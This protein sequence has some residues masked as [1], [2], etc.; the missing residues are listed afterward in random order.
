MRSDALSWVWD[1][2]WISSTDKT[3][4][5]FLEFHADR[6]N[7]VTISKPQLADKCGMS[8]RATDQCIKRLAHLQLISIHTKQ[9]DSRNKSNTYEV[10]KPEEL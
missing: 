6:N 10:R 2:D 7:Q 5:L 9:I 8:K 4:L 1:V 3:V